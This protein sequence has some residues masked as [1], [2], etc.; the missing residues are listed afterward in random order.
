M[1]SNSPN[2]NVLTESWLTV[3]LGLN[4]FHL[5]SARLLY[6]NFPTN[7]SESAK[8]N[9][10]IKDTPRLFIKYFITST[11]L[12]C[13]TFF[14]ALLYF[15]KLRM[16][17]KN[18]PDELANYLEKYGGYLEIC[19]HLRLRAFKSSLIFVPS[20]CSIIGFFGKSMNKFFQSSDLMERFFVNNETPDPDEMV[21]P[22]TRDLMFDP[23]FDKKHPK[24][25]RF[26]RNAIETF[27]KERP[28]NPISMTYLS[29]NS[30]FS[31]DKL[32]RE[33]ESYRQKKYTTLKF[34]Q[35]AL[36]ACT[37]LLLFL[38]GYQLHQKN[39]LAGLL[40]LFGSTIMFSAAS[41]AT[42]STDRAT[43]S[44]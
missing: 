30:L 29:K 9:E 20:I 11:A 12:N 31:D 15:E 10:V 18:S 2:N 3:F 44:V 39:S 28:I 16:E 35:R 5:I 26:E 4:I 19:N 27:L 13:I 25:H 8:W 32:K 38:G 37:I 14:F 40:F 34:S 6:R 41:F 42:S 17:I 21:C 24:I 43:P 22:I 1:D 23:V 33:V 36:G 7:T